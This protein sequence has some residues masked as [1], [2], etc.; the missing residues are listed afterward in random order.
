VQSSQLQTGDAIM[1]KISPANPTIRWGIIGAGNIAHQFAIG[2][3]FLPKAKLVAIASQTQD[4]AEN[5]SK[6]YNIPRIYKNYEK[7]AQDPE[8]DIVYIATPHGMHKDNC[9]ICLEN[10]KAVICEKPFTLN[11]REAQE[12]ISHAQQKN[13]FLMEAMWTRFFP[14][15]QKIKTLIQE[16]AIGEIVIIEANFGF[17]VPFDPKSRLFDPKLGGGS[18]LD[19]GV[20]GISFA[21]QFLGSPEKISAQAILGSTKVDEQMTTIL[22]YK[23]GATAIVYSSFLANTT[24]EALIIGTHG[25]IKIHAPFWMPQKFTITQY[26]KISIETKNISPITSLKKIILDQARHYPIVKKIGKTIKKIISPE[27]IITQKFIGNGYQYEAQE[28]MQC[29]WEKKAESAIMPISDT[30]KTI[31]IMDTIRKQCGVIYPSDS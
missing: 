5:F 12:V 21:T 25:Q 24:Q 29:L 4:K 3:S 30:L 11:Y 6:K 10:N 14:V 19:L 31:E 16:N 7:L 9:I 1:Q 18:L 2:L 26:P 27:K 8:I 15:I 20:Y 13:I 17:R 28:A 22:T 23:K